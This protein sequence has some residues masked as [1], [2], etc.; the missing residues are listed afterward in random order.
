MTQ[1]LIDHNSS[2]ELFNMEKAVKNSKR[3]NKNNVIIPVQATHEN[4]LIDRSGLVGE[5]PAM[6]KVYF[7]I[8]KVAPT[9]ATILIVGQSGTG[10]E[11]IAKALHNNSLRK[12]GPYIAVNCGA[13]T[14][15]LIGS[16]LFGHERG[17]FTGAHETHKGYFE[18]ASGGTLF[19]DEITE[20]P[21]EF[22]IKLLRVLETGKIIPVG[23]KRQIDIDVR[24]VAST[25]R[26]PCQAIK[27]GLLREDL[28]YRLNVFPLNVPSL[29]ERRDDVMLLSN[30]FLQQLNEIYHKNKTFT[31]KALGMIGSHRWSGNVRELK[32][33][34]HRAFIL[35]EDTI[36]ELYIEV[37]MNIL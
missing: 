7:A 27:D 26:T 9:T 14:P 15:E 31:M 23:G 16:A 13:F 4:P 28:Y 19:L 33:Q 10:K 37:A 22:Q 17:S 11:L 24:I 8:S 12:K 5:S 25:N 32:N 20:S 35:A 6:Q 1:V 18:Q 29:E 2:S 30:Y 36:C 3:N 34:I 21:P